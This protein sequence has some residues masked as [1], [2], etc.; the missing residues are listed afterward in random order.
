MQTRG[1]ARALFRALDR[2]TPRPLSKA[3]YI[4]SVIAT[5]P[6]RRMWLIEACRACHR[7]QTCIALLTAH[8]ISTLTS[9]A[10]ARHWQ[11]TESRCGRHPIDAGSIV[12][13]LNGRLADVL[14]YGYKRQQRVR[15]APAPLSSAHIWL[16][17]DNLTRQP[18]ARKRTDMNF[19]ATAVLPCLSQYV[20]SCRL[21][22]THR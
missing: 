19:S 3:S 1:C 10:L 15:R 4:V 2:A 8:R 21:S 9:A 22:G 5:L 13:A 7:P 20:W 14:S 18:R 6:N 12:R 16:R 11:P 17:L